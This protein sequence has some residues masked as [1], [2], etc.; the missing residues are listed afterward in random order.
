M[1]LSVIDVGGTSYSSYNSVEEVDAI[2]AVDPRR[3]TT[4]QALSEDLKK[5]YA[6]AASER[7]DL[8]RWKGS[9]TGGSAQL[10]AF[11]RTGLK[12]S[13]GNAIG[14]NDIPREL[15]RAHALLAGTIASTPGAA[16]QG[17]SASN[18]SEVKAGSATVKFFRHQVIVTGR[19]L[20]DETAFELIRRWLKGAGTSYAPA[21][22][23]Q[24]GD[25]EFSQR[26]RYGYRTE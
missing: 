25:S 11:P 26:E 21:A 18:I 14:Q 6:V 8:M 2:L 3:R 17:S 19:P 5:I 22:F 7:L 20:Q 1:T 10:T 13:E 24:D 23:G 15:E 12:D 16:E 9:K 4:W